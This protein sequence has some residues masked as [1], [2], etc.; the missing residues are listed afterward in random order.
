METVDAVQQRLKELRDGLLRL[1]KVLL[2]SEQRVYE[3]DV[4]R[5][6][7]R[8]QLLNLVLHDPWFHYLHELSEL[9]VHIDETMEAKEPVPN[10]ADAK[11]LVARSRALV[12]P[13]EEGRGFAR[14]YFE[15]M[16]RDPNVVIAH[17]DMLK[18]LERL[19]SQ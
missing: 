1:H 11:R 9:V 16:Q 18:T 12:S 14:R 10:E 4:E 19:G 2:E 8:G 6:T 13:A 7:S 17:S 5:I 3:R 15:A